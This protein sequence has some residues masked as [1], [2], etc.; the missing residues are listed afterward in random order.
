MKAVKF[1]VISVMLLMSHV[2]LAAVPVFG[3]T[4][5]SNYARQLVPPGNKAIVYIYQQND[6]SG[7]SP[8][9]QINNYEIGRLVPGSFTV[10]KLSP[11]KLKIGVGGTNPT[12]VSIISQAG[13]VYLFR[14]SVVQT[15][16]GPR[17]QLTGLPGSFRSD[18]AT[19]RLIKNPR[20]VTSLA[21]RVPAKPKE[22]VKKKKP[23]KRAT[24]AKPVE[25]P[26]S[27]PRFDLSSD[28]ASQPDV[29]IAPGGIGL[30]L[31]VGA[32]TLSEDTQTILGSARQFDE[33]VSGPYA[34]EGYYQFDS[35]FAFGGEL[36]G[37]TA[38]FT[39]AGVNQHDVDVTILFANVK[40]YFR[41][42][43][44]LQPYIGAGIGAATTDISGPTIGGSTS[45]LAYQLMAGIE[46]RS[47]NIGL[48]GEFK[49]V[50]ADTESDNNETIDV[51]ATGILA[52]VSFHF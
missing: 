34:I 4:T 49:Y 43:S 26:R 2:V 44:S 33:S 1:L 24:Q 15:S 17:A 6:S 11:G 42:D 39:T 21:G 28:P 38:V 12:S 48:F 35:G 19:M 25:K 20:A 27:A 9:I 36:M 31:K 51:S 8:S 22:P 52:G 10:W 46:Y 18:L 3:S 50:G 40:N 45:G 32:L 47:T 37:Y 16:A 41:V 29:A 14:L 13:K 23:A 30:M 7:V 5:E